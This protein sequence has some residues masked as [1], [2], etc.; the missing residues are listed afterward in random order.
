VLAVGAQAAVKLDG[1]GSDLNG[2]FDGMSLLK[3]LNSGKKPKVGNN[4]LVIGGG[5][6]AVDCART[7]LRLGAKDV[8]LVYRR[9]KAEMPAIAAEVKEAVDEGVKI[10]D[11]WGPKS[12]S[13][14]AGKVTAAVFQKYTGTKKGVP[15][16]DASTTKTIDCD[17]VILAIGQSVDL[18]LVSK[19]SAIKCDKGL[20]VA[21]ATGATADAAVYAAGDA[22]T[23]PATVIQAIAAGHKVAKA[24]AASFGTV[25]PEKYHNDEL[26]NLNNPTFQFHLREVTKEARVAET[27]LDAKDRANSFKEVNSGF[28]DKAACIKEARRCITCRCSSMGY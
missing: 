28:S 3:D 16:F 20:I 15:T 2:V 25:I 4:V 18:S 12:L 22:V 5:N 6:V 24:I 27:V 17:T 26:A 13:G 14:K 10:V 19:K 8:T 1:T 7:A 11:S 23:G 21:D 9:T